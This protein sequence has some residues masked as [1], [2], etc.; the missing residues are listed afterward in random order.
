MEIQ[1]ASRS[2]VGS[3][4]VNNE[5]CCSIVRGEGQILGTGNSPILFAVA[6]GMGGHPCGEVA[7]MLA[8]QAL[9][10]FLDTEGPSSVK[11]LQSVLEKR[12]FDID[13]QLRLN[14]RK[15]TVCLHMGTTLSV[16]II[17]GK[18]VVIAHV[19]D[20]R[21]YCLRDGELKLLT[22]DHTFVQEMVDKGALTAE[23]A[24]TAP[25]RN[26][27]TQA[28]GT[29]ESLE[30]V[31]TQTG[32]IIAG[33]R[34]LLSSDGLHDFVSFEDIE[35]MMGKGD[36]PEETAKE[37]LSLAIANGGQDDI[38]LIVVNTI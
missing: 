9:A 27:L 26:V 35:L 24:A 18:K 15:N 3:K 22:T 2:E 34:Y 14:T 32:D 33:D 38:T 17:F 8:C 13:K 36:D 16:M 29:D 5:D 25:H 31:S 7:S 12:F 20:T 19:G 21:I 10:G 28:I 37:L 6:D 30:F 11:G 1:Y 23:M 4:R